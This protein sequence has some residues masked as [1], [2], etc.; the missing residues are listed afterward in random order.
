MTQNN[1]HLCFG[2]QLKVKHAQ[3]FGRQSVRCQRRML[4]TNGKGKAVSPS[5]DGVLQAKQREKIQSEIPFALFIVGMLWRYGIERKQSEKKRVSLFC[6]WWFGCG[7]V[8]MRT[9]CLEYH[10]SSCRF[11]LIPLERTRVVNVSTN[12]I[13]IFPIAVV[14]LPLATIINLPNRTRDIRKIKRVW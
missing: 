2:T 1:F 11:Q 4:C 6:V 13:V 12:H 8:Q 7:T 10:L 9:F 14:A 3:V 5:W